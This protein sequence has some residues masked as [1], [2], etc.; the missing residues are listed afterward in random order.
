MD[1]FELTRQILKEPPPDPAA[2]ERALATLRMSI[3]SETPSTRGPRFRILAA[4][5]AFVIVLAMLL[6]VTQVAPFGGGSPAQA[7]LRRLSTLALRA[8]ASAPES[9]EYIKEHWEELSVE[10]HSDLGS[11]ASFE[12]MSRLAMDTWIASD[13]TGYRRTEVLSSD[14]ASEV[15]RA[16]WIDAGRP[17]LP[18]PGDIRLDSFTRRD[19]PWFDLT[20]LPTDPNALEAV[21]RSGQAIPWRTT[22]DQ[23]FLLIGSLLQQGNASPALRSALFEVASRLEGVELGGEVTDPLGR[24]GVGLA[25][26]GADARSQ[27]VFDP[28]TSQL[29]AIERYPRQ[30]DG[31]IGALAT[32]LA[33]DPAR[34]THVAP[35]S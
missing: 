4:A 1:E 7:E 3:A 20:D 13:G 35:Q 31:S 19:A 5:A 22:D 33:S 30:A 8:S 24:D 2:R 29:L 15:D 26:D 27:L 25:L 16:A 23:L 17:A 21:L 10:T 9:G 28:T 18:S 14:L 12:V 11:G 32:W 6:V 34:L